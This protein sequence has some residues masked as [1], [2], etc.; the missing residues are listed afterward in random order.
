MEDYVFNGRGG[1]IQQFNSI[2]QMRHNGSIEQ[3]ATFPSVLDG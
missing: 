3:I 2:I 1:I